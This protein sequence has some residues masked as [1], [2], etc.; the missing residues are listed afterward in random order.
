MGDSLAEKQYITAIIV[1]A[2]TALISV[3]G[4]IFG[5]RY[6]DKRSAKNQKNDTENQKINTENQE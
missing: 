6:V 4:I 1:F 3:L 5:N 2:L